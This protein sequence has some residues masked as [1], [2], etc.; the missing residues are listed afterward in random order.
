MSYSIF[1]NTKDKEKKEKMTTKKWAETLNGITIDKFPEMLE[2]KNKELNE[3][4]II[5]VYCIGDDLLKLVG[6]FNKDICAY[7]GVRI[8][9]GLRKSGELFILSRNDIFT[10][11]GLKNSQRE[12]LQ[13]IEA[14]WL[15]TVYE[16]GEFAI[17]RIESDIPHQRFTIFDSNGKDI[18]CNAMV[19]RIDNIN[20]IN[21][22]GK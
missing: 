15:V 9:V 21:Y 6:T 13:Y 11:E 2:E 16:N 5:V 14:L 19:L 8:Y 10:I 4:G 18:Y 22:K 20:I 12:Q 7:E 17:W 3:D 1:V